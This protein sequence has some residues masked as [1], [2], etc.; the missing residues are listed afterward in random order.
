MSHRSIARIAT[1]K[2]TALALVASA[3]LYVGSPLVAVSSADAGGAQTP[4]SAGF[5]DCKNANTGSHNGYVCPTDT[6]NTSVTA[7]GSG[8]STGSG[9]ALPTLS[10]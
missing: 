2:G 10:V 1:R 5:G 9:S 7:D 3:A 4:V 6:Q 8:A